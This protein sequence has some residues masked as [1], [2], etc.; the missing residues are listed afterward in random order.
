M[1]LWLKG[2]SSLCTRAGIRLFYILF[3]PCILLP[4]HMKQVFFAGITVAL[5]RKRNIS[6]SSSVTFDRIVQP[7]TLYREC[8]GVIISITMD[9]QQRGFDLLRETERRHIEINLRRFPVR[10]F[11]GLE[12]KRSQ[13]S[14]VSAAPGNTCLKQFRM[15]EQVSRHECAITVTTHRNPVAVA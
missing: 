6:Y 1:P 8:S 7:F 15:C 14:V 12:P 5:I 10:S 13:C 9:Q 4:H 3:E 11:L 2:F